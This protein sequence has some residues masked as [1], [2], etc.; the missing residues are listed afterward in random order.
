LS[1]RALTKVLVKASLDPHIAPEYI[2][3]LA[4]GGVDGTLKSRFA[5]WAASRRIRAKTGTLARSACL[6]GY[7]LGA[8]GEAPVA[9]SLLVNGIAGQASEIRRRQDELVSRIARRK[10]ATTSKPAAA[11]PPRPATAAPA[12]AAPPA[13][14]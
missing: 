4:I 14:P 13:A 8:H 12:P 10:A 1:A 7:V 9:F 11:P 2:A 3:Q 5:E 6:S